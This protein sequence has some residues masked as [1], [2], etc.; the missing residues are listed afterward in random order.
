LITP[1]TGVSISC[2]I[3]VGRLRVCKK[4]PPPP[5][6]PMPDPDTASL[7]SRPEQKPLPAP[8]SSTT[9]TSPSPSASAKRSAS[10]WSIRT[11]MALRRWGRLRVMVATWSATS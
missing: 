11:E 8:V 5:P 3:T 1:M 6:A 9:R 7:M 2:R 10:S 4:A